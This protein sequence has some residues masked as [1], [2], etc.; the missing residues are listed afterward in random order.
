[1]SLPEQCPLC[2]T[3]RERQSVVSN[4][5]YGN[6]DGMSRAFFYC[7][8]CDIR[9]QYPSLT[10]EQEA[11]FYASEFEGF[12]ASRAGHEGGWHKAE[13]HIQTSEMTRQ[14]RM[15]YLT[16]H[17][18]DS[19][20]ILE[21]GCSSGFMLLPLVLSGHVCTGIEPSGIF[22]EFVR[23]RGLPVYDSLDDLQKNQPEASFDVVLHFFVLEHIADPLAFLQKQLTLLKP[24]GKIIFEIPNAADPL[25]SVYDIPEF[26]R[27]YWS[28]AHHWY[29][30]E[31]SI[32]FLLRQ[33]GA[34]F[35]ILRDQRYDLSNHMTWAR[36]GKP[37]GMGRYTDALGLELEQ[38]Y[39]DEL[40]RI[41]KCDT[42]IAI[43]TKT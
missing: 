35:Q 9:Y 43:I 39:K 41:G 1:M 25:Y 12:M 16:S 17:L 22:S 2:A 34:E 11:H 19:V 32:Q 20:E 7:D 10:S 37:G 28:I 15:K 40:I 5:V 14:R 13:E 27:F 30:S 18:Q 24:G 26:E 23:S 4:H 42:L 33:L 29:F 3:S 38:R 36:D 6:V 21:V 8:F 31:K